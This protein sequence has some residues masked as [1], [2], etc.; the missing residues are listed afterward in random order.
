[1]VVVRTPACVDLL[2]QR[3]AAEGRT[4]LLNFFQDDCYGALC[5]MRHTSSRP[6]A[7]PAAAAA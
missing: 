6:P 4:V 1:M 7:A 3:A 5:I 2:T